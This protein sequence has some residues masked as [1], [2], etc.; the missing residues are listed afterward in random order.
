METF[1]DIIQIVVP[2][3]L[4]FFTAYY[5]LKSFLRAEAEKRKRTYKIGNQK[6]VT[7][8]K[9]Q[10]FERL[11]LLL[12]R[13]SLQ[14]LVVRTQRSGMTS[15]NLQMELIKTIRSEFDH[16]LV[17]QI[18]ISNKTWEAIKTAKEE[19][20]KAINI[21]AT[22]INE[23]AES[24]ELVNMIFEIISRLEKTPTEVALQ[25]LKEEAR[26]VIN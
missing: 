20:T 9:L 21:A 13:I 8:L 11:T 24:M 22:R 23:N 15:R 5:L 4:V 17:Q 3:A 6:I 25:I 10:A 12:E 2:A 14:S 1:L 26:S 19:T 16:N 7:P 18:Y